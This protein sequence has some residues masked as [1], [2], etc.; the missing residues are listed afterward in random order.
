MQ[1]TVSWTGYLMKY[2][3][4][5]SYP[6]VAVEV[7]SF[8]RLVRHGKHPLLS[9]RWPANKRDKDGYS[10]LLLQASMSACSDGIVGG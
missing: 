1:P 4:F 6:E 2:G 3:R 8:W 10:E 5:A 7:I 9:K